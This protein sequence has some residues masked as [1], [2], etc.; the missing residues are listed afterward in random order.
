VNWRSDIYGARVSQLGA[1][2]TGDED[3]ILLSPETPTTN[4][5]SPAVAFDGTDYLLAWS[6]D[7]NGNWYDIYACQMG[8]DRYVGAAYP[9]SNRANNYPAVAAGPAQGTVLAAYQSLTGDPPTNRIWALAGALP[10]TGDVGTNS[11]KR[12][13]ASFLWDAGC[14]PIPPVARVWNDGTE[15]RSFEAEFTIGSWSSTRTVLGL[16]PGETRAVE[17]DSFPLT[18]GLFTGTC[19]TKLAGD[20]DNTNDSKSASFQGCTF[21]DFFD[22][23]DFGFTV[24]ADNGWTWGEPANPPWTAPPMDAVACGVGVGGS[25]DAGEN[26]TLTSPVYRAAQD[27]PSIAFQHNF[28]T[29]AG[30]DG[31]N[32]S[33]ST[34]N[35]RNWFW[36]TPVA[37]LGYT[38]TVN[39]L[40][41]QGWSGN[42]SGWQHSVFTLDEVASGVPFIARW[43]FASDE[44][45]NGA[46][47]LIDEV[48]GIACGISLDRRWPQKGD[49]VVAALD[50]SPNPVSTCG[51]VSYAL[52]KDCDVSI[53]L[54]DITGALVA[55]VR[56]TGFT[57]GSHTAT[58]DATGLRSGVYF[59]KMEGQGDSRST[60]VIVQ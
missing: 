31:G 5:R 7:R 23:G 9:I 13:V 24:S 30:H 51:Q 28:S 54:Y 36:P 19:E 41:R 11:I 3:G 22:F 33:Y 35:G 38:G 1:V 29:Q 15:P 27:Y 12:P 59:L 16:R 37:G 58:M 48:A 2:V 53:K 56:T 42:S 10:L 55:P 25:Y 39:A 50:V 46:G 40:G 26:T 44:A 49:S 18:V 21:I 14:W 32:F 8:L 57:R 52:L 34:D 45:P 47:W 20:D 60:K 43:L 6:D 17:F 4:Q